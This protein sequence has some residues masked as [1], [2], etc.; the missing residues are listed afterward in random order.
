[1]ATASDKLTPVHTG[2]TPMMQQYLRIKSE[3]PDML[4]FYRM[5]DFYE[6]FYDDARRAA[7]LIDIT[8]TA[9]GKSAGEP[10]PM[11]GIPYHAAESYLARLVRR[12]ESVAICEQV[13]D[14][15]T[16]KG[17]VERKV[18]RV[19]TPGTLTD[20]ALLDARRDNVIAALFVTKRCAGLAWM[21]LSVGRF[22][23]TEVESSSALQS[24]LERL[25]PAELLIE[26][27]LDTSAWLAKT[28][29]CREMPPWHF[30]GESSL[31]ALCKQFGTQDLAG[32]GC[33]DLSAAINAAGCL[34]QYIK[35]TQRTHL[36][37]IESLQPVKQ[38]D[39]L[40]IDAAT[41]RNLELEYS[42]A[43][44]D[45]HTLAGI[46]DHCATTMGSRLL[47]RWLNRPIRNRQT[48]SQRLNAINTLLQT[49]NQSLRDSL[50]QLGDL[51]RILTRIALESARPRDLAH[52]RTALRLLPEI[53]QSL[54][55]NDAQLAMLITAI[56]N[57]ADTHEHL[58]RAI[59]EEPPMLIRDGGVLAQ[60]YDAELDELRNIS[61]NADGY[62]TDLE[63][64]EKERTGIA[65]LKVGYNRVHGYFIEISKGQADKAPDD[66]IRR[67]TLKGAE[68]YVTPEL[69][70]FE[71]KVL[72]ARER[73]LAR[74][75]KLYQALL[76]SF[77]PKLTE[78]QTM[79]RAL[80]E[81]DVLV[82]LAER[83]STLNLQAPTLTD[84]PG[85]DIR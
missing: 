61:R 66:Y 63:E 60:G 43:G 28:E 47:R 13:G 38:S 29:R 24:E 85:L 77:V 20:E 19:I 84:E 18:V 50:S 11:A 16:A 42:L 31:N 10:I 75:K 67:Q 56:G 17:P 54:N 39:A 48:L 3:F 37:H 44:R 82:N 21:D 7:E 69:K 83:A 34:L 26:E 49:D 15:K 23:V 33:A 59:I 52:L 41:R 27:T 25:S 46:M 76:Q 55:A 68:R 40:L 70:D 8:L 36:P 73:S 35:D 71:G 1:M 74:E 45:E 80:A 51:E 57:H 6:L 65:T 78:L 72:S 81:T 58:E 5:G 64:R 9:R 79:A 32:F 2:H 53:R 22:Y 30:D 12:G 62:L 14:P 4:V